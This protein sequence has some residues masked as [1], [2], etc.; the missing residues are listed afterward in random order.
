MQKKDQFTK[1]DG[2]IRPNIFIVHGWSL[3]QDIQQ[4]WRPLMN[5]LTRAG[6][7]VSFLKLPGL[8]TQLN[9]VWNL[10][11]YRDWVLD[12]I[13]SQQPAVLIGHSFGGQIAVTAAAQKPANLQ[14]LILIAPAGMIAKSLPKNIKRSLFKMIAKIGNFVLG[15]GQIAELA[16]KV[17]Y[18]LAGE[19]D[20]YQASPKLKKTMVNA[21]NTEIVD[22]LPKIQVPTLLIW[23][24]DD[25][26]TPYKHAKIF[27]HK[28]KNSQLIE[29]KQVG[30]FP[31]RDQPDLV[32]KK[33]LQFLK[34]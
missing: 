16:R 30:H 9:E 13:E 27:Q 32:A 33:I 6:Y 34:N 5:E 8:Q 18:K 29:L 28:I 26:F 20:Y 2:T 1:N 17:L 7:C 15:K 14:H 19:T 31:Y 11:D 24:K 23:G 3:R 4:Q 21:L 12:Q 25:R 22:Q 10:S